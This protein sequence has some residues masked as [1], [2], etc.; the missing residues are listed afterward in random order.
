MRSHLHLPAPAPPGRWECRA[1]HPITAVS[2][3][4]QLLKQFAS[5]HKP[6]QILT[7]SAFTTQITHNPKK[8][9]MDNYELAARS[10][11]TVSFRLDYKSQVTR[12][13]T[14]RDANGYKL[15]PF[16]QVLAQRKSL[17]IQPNKLQSNCL[18]QDE[19]N[20]EKKSPI[21]HVFEIHI[22]CKNNT[23]C[24]ENCQP[25]M[26]DADMFVNVKLTRSFS[27]FGPILLFHIKMW[28]TDWKLIQG[29]PTLLLSARERIYTPY[30]L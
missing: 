10:I 11:C 22:R 9:P 24:T 1:F 26:A 20:V 6:C 2:G 14:Y 17:E 23:H 12:H 18:W 25:W 16:S 28:T 30:T 19:T 13:F 21:I 5:Q 8:P 4:V 7:S 3:A 15:I 29:R 27:E